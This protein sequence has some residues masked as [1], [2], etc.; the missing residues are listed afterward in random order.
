MSSLSAKY[1][2]LIAAR[3]IDLICLGIGENG[4]IAFNDPPV[5]DLEDPAL[6]KC[7]QLDDA[8][9]QQQVNDG[10]FATLSVV[11]AHALTLTIPVF[12]SAR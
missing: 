11:P 5:A 6:V 3:P 12:R 7:V 2:A 10:C 4:H 8:C 9:R 1:A